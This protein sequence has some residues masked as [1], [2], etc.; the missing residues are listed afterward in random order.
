M[1]VWI[2][3]AHRRALMP[4]HKRRQLFFLNTTPSACTAYLPPTAETPRYIYQPQHAK[5]F[6]ATPIPPR[7]R[8]Y[9]NEKVQHAIGT[10]RKMRHAGPDTVTMNKDFGSHQPPECRMQ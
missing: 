5:T 1:V 2:G 7:L 9:M 4:F 6:D 3:V 10:A 8:Q